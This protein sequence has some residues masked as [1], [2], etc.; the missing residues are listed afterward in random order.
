MLQEIE[1]GELK[2]W[3]VKVKIMKEIEE[4]KKKYKKLDIKKV[5]KNEEYKKIDIGVMEMKRKKEKYL[6]EV[7]N[8]ELQKQNIVKGIGFQKEKMIKES[9]L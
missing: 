9:I 5:W 2:K 6:K 3:K 4:E 8:E 1:K 7:E